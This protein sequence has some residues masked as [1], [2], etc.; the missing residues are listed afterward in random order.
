MSAKQQQK[1]QAVAV[2]HATESAKPLDGIEKLTVDQCVD[3]SDKTAMNRYG[4]E[5][6]L[7]RRAVCGKNHWGQSTLGKT[8]CKNASEGSVFYQAVNRYLN[9]VQP[10]KDS[11]SR[12]Y[13]VLLAQCSLVYVH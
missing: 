4:N 6:L 1:D 5:D 12:V 10:Y 13:Q 3:V 11:S 2:A 7:G 9:C 8:V